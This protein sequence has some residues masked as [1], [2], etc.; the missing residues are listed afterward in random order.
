MRDEWLAERQAKGERQMRTPTSKRLDREKCRL[1]DP[2][3]R[4][5]SK[6]CC[7]P[8]RPEMQ[9]GPGGPKHTLP[10]EEQKRGRIG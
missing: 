10:S 5:V 1:F 3:A 8:S 6:P 9:D 4:D 2:H 7:L